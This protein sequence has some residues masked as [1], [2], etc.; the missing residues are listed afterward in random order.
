[1]IRIADLSVTFGRGTVLET[2]ALE[3]IDLAIAEGEF[4]TVIGSNGAGKST[5]LNALSG[6][7]RPERGRIESMVRTSPAGPRRSVRG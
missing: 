5:L 7:A 2:R 4:V 3:A 1:M 6:D